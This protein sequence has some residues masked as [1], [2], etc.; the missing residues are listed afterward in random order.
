VRIEVLVKITL[1]RL[2]W[3]TDIKPGKKNVPCANGS[4]DKGQLKGKINKCEITI[5]RGGQALLA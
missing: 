2:V 3:S 4:I 1:G 5:M